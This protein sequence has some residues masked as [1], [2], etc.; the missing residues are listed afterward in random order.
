[1]PAT[2]ATMLSQ[3]TV[4]AARR[5]YGMGGPLVVE[6]PQWQPPKRML[7]ALSGHAHADVT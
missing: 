1:M 7:V 3:R 2:T 6:R 4:R 5:A